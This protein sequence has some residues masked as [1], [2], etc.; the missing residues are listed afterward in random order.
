M[1]A[2]GFLSV[3][4]FLECVDSPFSVYPVSITSLRVVRAGSR[5]LTQSPVAAVKRDPEL[6]DSGLGQE[7]PICTKV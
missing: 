4:R 3:A 2:G 6:A 1:R 5:C 7:C